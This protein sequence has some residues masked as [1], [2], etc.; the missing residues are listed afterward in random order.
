MPVITA[1]NSTGVVKFVAVCSDRRYRSRQPKWA[2]LTGRWLGTNGSY[3]VR[4]S[5]RKLHNLR[6]YY[7]DR[8]RNERT[9]PVYRTKSDVIYTIL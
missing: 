4:H 7:C 5:L 2:E 3:I 1:R 8:C 9:V 6:T